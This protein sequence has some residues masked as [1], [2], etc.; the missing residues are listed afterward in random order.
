MTMDA[1]QL[2]RHL[3]ER[4]VCFLLVGGLA[5][6]LNG[7]VRTTEDVDILV[8]ADTP[9]IQALLAALASW[10]EGHAHE[11]AAT[12]FTLEPGAIRLTEDYP[13]D[14]F[15]LMNGKTYEQLLP[16]APR[17]PAGL[18]YMNIA[19]LIAAKQASRRPQDQLDV[20]RLTELQR[21]PPPAPPRKDAP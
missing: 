18:A 12:D 1:L 8:A 3:Q 16:Q 2:L 15:T 5:C 7:H 10:G 13:L 17:T 21:Q 9:N 20:L 4:G 14:I 6:A 11:L 19:D